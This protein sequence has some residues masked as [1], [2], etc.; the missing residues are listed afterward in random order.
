[1]KKLTLSALIAS[2]MSLPAMASHHEAKLSTGFSALDVDGNGVISTQEIDDSDA[3]DVLIK[4]DNDD[5]DLITRSEFNAYVDAHPNKFSG[6]IVMTVR[7]EGTNDAVLVKTGEAK[8]DGNVNTS[9][10][11]NK[12]DFDTDVA[13]FIAF[14]KIDQDNNGELTLY[15]VNTVDIDASFDDMDMDNDDLVTRIEYNEYVVQA[16]IE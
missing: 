8:I 14:D 11:E 16:D 15:E 1:M 9:T 4:M 12:R 2:A 13:S 3:Q 10:S 7:A 6:D 5:D